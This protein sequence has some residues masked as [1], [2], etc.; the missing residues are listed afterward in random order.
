MNRP[1]RPKPICRIR[2]I[3]PCEGLPPMALKLNQL[4]QGAEFLSG[5]EV[6]LFQSFPFRGESEN[7]RQ[8]FS[9]GLVAGFGAPGFF[10][11]V[12]IQV[13]AVSPDAE[14]FPKQYLA[15]LRLTTKPTRYSSRVFATGTSSRHWRCNRQAARRLRK[16]G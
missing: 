8:V 6:P 4:A 9:L 1:E 15:G 11:S 14:R 3:P 16:V 7:T 5:L 10:S 2:R 12:S 13:F